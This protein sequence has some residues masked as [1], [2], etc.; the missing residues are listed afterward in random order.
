MYLLD[1]N[2]IIDVVANRASKGDLFAD[3]VAYLVENRLA[4]I[5]SSQITQSGICLQ[6]AVSPRLAR[7]LAA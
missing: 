4:L 6:E 7:L 3:L 1:N 2:F 5:A